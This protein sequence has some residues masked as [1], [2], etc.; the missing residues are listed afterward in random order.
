M[1][2]AFLSVAV[3][4]SLLSVA[5]AFFGACTVVTENGTLDGGT[6]TP[7]G[8]DATTP[9]S[10]GNPEASAEAS[11]EA[12]A[13][14]GGSQPD[15]GCTGW[16]CKVA[17]CSEAGMPTTLTGTI[18]DPAGAV[19]LYNIYVYVPNATPAPIKP[20]NPTCAQCQAPASG[21][22]I[23]GT[24]TGDDGKFT[25]APKGNDPWGVPSGDNVP[26]VIQSGKWRRQL[27]IP[28]VDACKTTDLDAVLGKDKLR[29]PKNSTEGDM[30]NIA[31][32]TGCDPAECFL[33][34]I[35][36]DDSEFV[37]PDGTNGHV[38]LYQGQGGSTIANG[39]DSTFTY[40]W[41]SDPVNLAQYDIVFNA[42]ECTPYDRDPSGGTG[43]YDAMHSYLENGG[44]LF[45]THYYGN[46]FMPAGAGSCTNCKGQSDVASVAAWQPWGSTGGGQ[47]TDLIDM[48]FPKGLSM[49]TWLQNIGQTQTVG[50]I[51]LADIRDD[52]T[53]VLPT[54]CS[55]GTS[56]LSTQWINAADV[57]GGVAHPRYLS[58]NTP[59][60]KPVTDQCG[61]AVFSD[62]HLS[63]SNGSSS[64]QFPAECAGTP[65]PG[66]AAN[67]KALEFL[68]FDL[69]TCVQDDSLPPT[70]PNPAP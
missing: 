49:A 58:F 45:A 70:V 55:T 36:I 56:C 37:A 26:L 57:D 30:P 16:Q 2:L 39:Q 61:R 59:V 62:V 47:E 44:R 60:K 20:G 27:V 34:H 40:K 23:I 19:P 13:G 29:L 52:V 38:H 8:N 32:T 65:Q 69:G 66:Y 5:V 50:Q 54:G 68:F 25:L 17:D 4:V 21:S 64:Y 43:A 51:T 11:A 46:W 6:I 14:D 7:P 10:G 3:P 33:R 41:W 15:G 18:Y 22:P 63:G 24:Q 35:G 42:C 48:T 67:E 1:R 53:N 9:D 31:L 12:A 28:H